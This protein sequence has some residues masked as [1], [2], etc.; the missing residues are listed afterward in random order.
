MQAEIVGMCEVN[1][2]TTTSIEEARRAIA[3]MHEEGTT[4]L[5]SSAEEFQNRSDA[6]FTMFTS[7][8]KPPMGATALNPRR[9]SSGFCLG[10]FIPGTS[11]QPAPHA[12]YALKRLGRLG[13]LFVRHAVGFF[14]VK[15][16]P[17]HGD[18]GRIPP[19]I[20]RLRPSCLY[21]LRRAPWCPFI[22]A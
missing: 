6:R 13:Q 5:E 11:R 20:P 10:I 3:E 22:R 21:P 2:M 17:L 14:F 4:A 1:D 19:C 8:F 18:V 9:S 7:L 15:K 12:R 16:N